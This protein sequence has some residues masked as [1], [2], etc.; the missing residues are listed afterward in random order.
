MPLLCVLPHC[1]P[2]AAVRTAACPLVRLCDARRERYMPMRV[3][4]FTFPALRAAL[5][6]R[7]RD[8][9]GWRWGCSRWGGFEWRRRYRRRVSFRKICHQPRPT[10]ASEKLCTNELEKCE[11][12]KGNDSSRYALD[13]ACGGAQSKPLLN[14]PPKFHLFSQIH[15]VPSK[16]RLRGRRLMS[17]FSRMLYKTW[18]G[19]S[20]QSMARSGHEMSTEMFTYLDLV[21]VNVE[22]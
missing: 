11:H 18:G 17:K 9:W 10:N 21:L 1:A 13:R 16:M 22:S 6:I 15:A 19:G 5:Q 12:S 7:L 2:R 3:C 20:R 8:D 4:L 14:A